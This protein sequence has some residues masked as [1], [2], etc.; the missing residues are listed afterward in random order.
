MT[1]VKYQVGMGVE[2]EYEESIV[3]VYKIPKKYGESY[4]E[5]VSNWF[6]GSNEVEERLT[7]QVE[8]NGGKVIS[9]ISEPIS[10]RRYKRKTAKLIRKQYGTV[11]GL[12]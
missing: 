4:E 5:T 6:N 11:K 3:E 10:K 8:A 7:K 1:E 12:L 9:V 2:R